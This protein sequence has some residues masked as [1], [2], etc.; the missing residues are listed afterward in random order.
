[1]SRPA[2]LVLYVFIASAL[3]GSATG[4]PDNQD[5]EDAPS[6]YFNWDELADSGTP[7]RV[8]LDIGP[9]GTCTARILSNISF[10]AIETGDKRIVME[11][12][13]QENCIY[14]VHAKRSDGNGDAQGTSMDLSD[15]MYFLLC[16]LTVDCAHQA[17][18]APPVSSGPLGGTDVE[19]KWCRVADGWA[20]TG[21]PD[22]PTV[23][24]T[25][26][27]QEVKFCWDADEAWIEEISGVCFANPGSE[28]VTDAG[29]C[30]FSDWD[31]GPSPTAYLT[32]HGYFEK[33]IGS[34]QF[35]PSHDMWNTVHGDAGTGRVY[36][37]GDII[38][39]YD[40]YVT[41]DNCGASE[42]ESAF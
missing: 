5:N 13:D 2:L 17:A 24:Y 14:D 15:Q 35:R 40:G 18:D 21:I 27:Y 12:V 11:P 36:C 42:P 1:M 8:Q 39:D 31:T 10:N 4:D 16:Q 28:W 3:V 23:V 41:V 29:E 33:A 6:F 19:A 22:P 7:E 26:V 9:R 37:T 38:G 20:H 30:Y 32:I 25:R 34:P